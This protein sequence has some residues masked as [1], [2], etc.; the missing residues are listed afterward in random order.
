MSD[1]DEFKKLINLFELKNQTYL[2]IL[3]EID[4]NLKNRNFNKLKVIILDLYDLI[5]REITINVN[6][7]N[8]YNRFGKALIIMYL[9]KFKL[10]IRIRNN[11]NLEF[12]FRTK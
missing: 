2:D 5:E 6:R 7:K 8:I 1:F 4:L 12:I 10:R 11:V 9:N 3:G